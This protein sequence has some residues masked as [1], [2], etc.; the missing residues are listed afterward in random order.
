MGRIAFLMEEPSM[1]ETLRALLPKLFPEWEEEVDWVPIVFSGKQD[2]LKGMVSK[3]RGWREPGIRFVILLDNDNGDCHALKEK[4]LR[5][6]ACRQEVGVL[7]RIVCQEL[8]SWFLGDLAA[9]LKAYPGAQLKPGH[10]PAR[11]RN[12]DAVSNASEE[13]EKLTETKAKVVRA[14]E[15]APRMTPSQ[16]LS[17][18]FQVFI[19]GTIR[20]AAS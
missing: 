12:P 17:R 18:S 7:V 4:L 20:L 11:F 3:L 16:N 5:N 14:K 10:P 1:L 15:I 6:A 13:I 2:L 19:E 9:V 8:E